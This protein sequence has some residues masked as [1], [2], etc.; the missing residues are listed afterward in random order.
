MVIPSRRVHLSILLRCVDANEANQLMKEI[1]KGKCGPHMNGHLLAKKIMRLG[2][3]WLTMEIDCV[4]HMR[5]CYKCQVYEDRI[6]VP[7][8]ELH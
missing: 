4:Q 6:K 2:Y 1:Y 8:I 5:C 3:F 7:L